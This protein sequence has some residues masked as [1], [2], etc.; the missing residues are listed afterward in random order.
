M[1]DRLLLMGSI[2]GAALSSSKCLP[3]NFRENAVGALHRTGL[4]LA[5][6]YLFSHASRCGPMHY[7]QRP[8][9][10]EADEGREPRSGR[11]CSQISTRNRPS[12]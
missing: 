10:M 12:R 3:R 11:I 7:S 2:V 8:A 6:Q 9:Q 4:S 5:K 1:S